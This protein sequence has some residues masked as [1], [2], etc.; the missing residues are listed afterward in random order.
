MWD[1]CPRIKTNIIPWTWSHLPESLSRPDYSLKIPRAHSW[2]DMPLDVLSRNPRP[3]QV[4]VS[5][6]EVLC[7]S[8]LTDTG[9]GRL[10][11]GTIHS[12]LAQGSE[13]H[14]FAISAIPINWR[15]CVLAFCCGSES[16]YVKQNYPPPGDPW[17]H[18][19]TNQA[20]VGYVSYRPKFQPTLRFLF[21]F[22]GPGT[23]SCMFSKL[24][25]KRSYSSR[26]IRSQEV[27]CE[28]CTC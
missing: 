2:I 25:Y 15:S 14:E 18:V 5:R 23:P 3:P 12:G 8:M 6:S 4:Y 16:Q 17:S 26:Y 28:N 10:P 11:N 20:S 22:V 9:R 24:T 27:A 7:S 1:C 19:T 21:F 13:G